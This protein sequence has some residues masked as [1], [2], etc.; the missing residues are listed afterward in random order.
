[1]TVI[2]VESFVNIL[3]LITVR[4]VLSQAVEAM[5]VSSTAAVEIQVFIHFVTMQVALR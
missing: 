3:F 2:V 1:M 4:I 5:V